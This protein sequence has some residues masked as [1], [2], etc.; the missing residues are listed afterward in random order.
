MK[1][2][3]SGKIKS[4]IIGSGVAVT[5][6]VGIALAGP[7]TAGESYNV[8]LTDVPPTAGSIGLTVGPQGGAKQPQR[9]QTCFKGTMGQN[10]DTHVKAMSGERVRTKVYPTLDCKTPL[11]PATVG[12]SMGTEPVPEY[13]DTDNYWFKVSPTRDVVENGQ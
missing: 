10:I 4:L 3:V 5:A 1:S 13:L 12:E 6:A 2:V 11:G 7:A 8:M 9:V